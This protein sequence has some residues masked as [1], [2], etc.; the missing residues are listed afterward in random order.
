M[1][2]S[3]D[4]VYYMCTGEP[5]SKMEI[6]RHH[7]YS[8]Q[9]TVGDVKHKK[10]ATPLA[11]LSIPRNTSGITLTADASHFMS[12]SFLHHRDAN[13]LP[14]ITMIEGIPWVSYENER[15]AV[16][17]AALRIVFHWTDCRLK[18]SRYLSK[19]MKVATRA[20][21]YEHQPYDTYTQKYL[22]DKDHDG[23]FVIHSSTP[24]S[25]VD[26]RTTVIRLGNPV[27]PADSM[28][29][30]TSAGRTTRRRALQPSRTDEHDQRVSLSEGVVDAKRRKPP[31]SK[32]Y[33]AIATTSSVPPLSCTDTTVEEC[34]HSV[35]S[36]AKTNTCRVR[37]HPARSTHIAKDHR[38]LL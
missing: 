24:F 2:I 29:E 35:G 12:I 17:S 15:A 27:P 19:K 13:G 22:V 6:T 7:K 1:R 36:Q 9:L 28:P 3:I 30:K 8:A 20:V 25:L 34:T 26:N 23:S 5:I 4:D 14:S 32:R 38:R 11:Y 18:L 10:V 31:P 33:Q 16:H 37:K 21:L